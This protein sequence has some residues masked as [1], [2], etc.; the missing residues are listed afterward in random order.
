MGSMA[1][2]QY[3][4]TFFESSSASHHHQSEEVWVGFQKLN[5]KWGGGGKIKNKNKIIILNWELIEFIS[6]VQHI[7]ACHHKWGNQ[8]KNLK[9]W[10]VGLI[11]N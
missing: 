8:K 11:C 2:N 6:H 7:H 9:N 4:M 1:S 5:L 3:F 10:S